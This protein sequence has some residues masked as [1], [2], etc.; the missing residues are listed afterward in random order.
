ML[1]SLL[2]GLDGSE[3]NEGAWELGLRWAKAHDAVAVGVAVAEEPDILTTEA[4]LLF[5]TDASAPEPLPRRLRVRAHEAIG[6]F[7]RRAEEVGVRR[8]VIEAVGSPW[9]RIIEEAERHDLIV[10]GRQT[11]FEF[12]SGSHGDETVIKVIRAAPRPVVTVL[13]APAGGEAAVVAYDG[14]L[15]AARALHAFEASGL[16]R[17]GPVHVVGVSSDG[18]GAIRGVDRAVAFLRSHDI[19]ARP[20]AIRSDRDPAGAILEQ[21]DRLG[22]GL[23]VMGAYGQPALRE[24]LLGSVTRTA[25]R[26]CA[27]PV[28]CYH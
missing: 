5:D 21:V 19:D 22:A 18:A 25:L 26:E 13:R 12:G 6:P 27:A 20:V 28:F 11:H 23:L 9:A 16:A 8:E 1:R 24:F 4:A 15:Q 7:A 3:D 2:I 17:A 14:S 10:L